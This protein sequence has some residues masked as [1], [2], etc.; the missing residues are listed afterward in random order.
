M[1][2]TFTNEVRVIPRNRRQK[3]F[4]LLENIAYF[5]H[6]TP[7]GGAEQGKKSVCTWTQHLKNPKSI[8]WNLASWLCTQISHLWLASNYPGSEKS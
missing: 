3:T 8:Q 4:S 2:N 5:K 6:S 1:A 7:L